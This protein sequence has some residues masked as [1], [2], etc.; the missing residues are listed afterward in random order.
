MKSSKCDTLA[1][2]IGRQNGQKWPILRLN[3]KVLKTN[4][5]QLYN[6][7]EVSYAKIHIIFEK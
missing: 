1:E 6:I 2:A 4:E 5:N 7:I 3:F